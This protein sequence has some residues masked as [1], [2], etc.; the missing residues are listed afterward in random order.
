MKKKFN[1]R[2]WF[3]NV[4]WYHYKWIALGI[5]FGIFVFGI[6]IYEMVT[7]VEGDVNYL[8]VSLD[9]MAV[10]R[11]EVINGVFKEKVGDINGDG[12][13]GYFYDLV[14]AN[15]GE[16]DKVKLQS[17]FTETSYRLYLLKGGAYELMEALTED[18]F[19]E[20]LSAHGFET[21]PEKPY[22]AELSGAPLLTEA[23]LD[24]EPFYAMVRSLSLDGS[25][26]KY[27]EIARQQEGAL[28]C[29]QAILEWEAPIGS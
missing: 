28:A 29:I 26:K 5:L 7:R 9:Y 19:W 14:N 27:E 18:V 1:F 4:F 13:P 21:V 23:G 17:A 24:D 25:N 20:D 11:T 8:V 15:G 10:D 16:I 6:F 12:T 2:H 22:L 3:E